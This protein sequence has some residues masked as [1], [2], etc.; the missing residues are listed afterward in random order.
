MS[1]IRLAM[2]IRAWTVLGMPPS[3]RV[4]PTTAAPYFFTRGR[5]ASKTASSPFT[6]LTMALPQYTRR[7]PSSTLGSVESSWRGASVTPWRALHRAHHHLGLV[8]LGQAHVHVQDV[9]PGLRLL[10]GLAQHIVH[11]P[12]L[13]G[14]LHALLP[15]G[16]DALTDDPHPVDGDHLHAAAHGGGDMP[17]NFLYRPALQGPAEEGNVL[18]SSAAAAA[19]HLHPQAG[20]L[21]QTLRK[22][23]RG[24]VIA[25][26]LDRVL[27]GVGF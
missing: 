23:L 19:E 5:M 15:G 20:E 1:K 21:C 17:G 14:L 24:D 7:A 26:T 13:Q 10:Q 4:R 2:S 11:I 6:E 8:D 3:S 22:L 16:V 9:R 18:G 25:G 12:G 27:T